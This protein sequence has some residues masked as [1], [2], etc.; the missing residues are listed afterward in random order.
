LQ[1]IDQRSHILDMRA[2]CLEAV[3]RRCDQLT[4][5]RIGLH[6]AEVEA[7]A[8]TP[9]AH[10]VLEAD[11]VVARVGRQRAPVAW[12]GS[13]GDVQRQRRV[14]HRARQNALA[15]HVG[16]RRLGG[17]LRDAPVARL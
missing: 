5:F 17:I 9:A 13:G 7:Q 4:D 14:E 2:R 1:R 8:D 12:I 6:V 15:H 10:S 11:R 16:E 3:G